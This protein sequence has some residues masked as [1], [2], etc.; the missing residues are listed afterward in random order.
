[1]GVGEF[2][3][4]S[5]RPR[6]K[7]EEGAETTVNVDLGLRLAEGE[8]PMTLSLSPST[9]PGEAPIGDNLLLASLDIVAGFEPKLLDRRNFSPDL[10]PDGRDISS[11]SLRTCFVGVGGY[12]ESVEV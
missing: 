8:P 11:G 12:S 3:F 10:E 9:L 1:M 6:V 2:K 7:D 4:L 5:S